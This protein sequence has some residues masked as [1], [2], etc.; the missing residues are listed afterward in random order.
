MPLVINSNIS[1]LN[2][3]RQ[4][5]NSG[6][7]LATAMERLSSGKRINTA[8]DD[9]AGLAISNRMTSQ[10]RGLDQAI[11]NAND[12][13]SLIQTAEGALDETT[14]I[15]QRMRELSIQSAN[16]IYSPA[17]R[18]NLDREVQQLKEELDRIAEST[19]FNGQPLLD[20]SL[21][22]MLLQVGSQANQTIKVSIGSM[23]SDSLGGIRGDVTGTGMS[24][25]FDP[26]GTP[27]GLGFAG[28]VTIN[29]QVLLQADL[30]GATNMDE[31]LELI[32]ENVQGVKASTMVEVKAAGVGTGVLGAGDSV[33]LSLIR[34]D[35]TSEGF[36]ITGTNTLLELAEKI[37]TQTE[38]AIK[39]TIDDD[40][41]LVLGSQNAQRLEVTLAGTGAAGATGTIATA[42]AS[43]IL[44]DTNPDNGD[45]ITVGYA[46]ADAALL[47]LDARTNDTLTGVVGDYTNPLL[48]GDMLIN[49][50]EIDGATTA[51]ELEAAINA[52][53]AETGVFAT[54]AAGI[55]TLQS[56]EEVS[57]AYTSTAAATTTGL[58]ATNSNEFIGN[59]IST[60]DISTAEGAQAAI[61]TIDV[62]LESISA[63]RSDMGAANNRLDFTINNLM[64]V[65]ENTSA[66]RSRIMDADFAAETAQL[67]RAQVLQQ[68]SQAM[69][70]QANALPQQVLQLLQG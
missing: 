41:K 64:V 30:N 12:G 4:L 21:G 61:A 45:D 13:I 36:V 26:A 25:T 39:A 57:I 47:G 20:G 60:I 38:G 29:G 2:A 46:A 33:S 48:A 50:V 54:N 70:A 1:S 18:A 22:D 49:G 58:Q 53:A 11:R 34:N 15:L 62:A 31:F 35:G 32:N 7:E 19:T 6:N 52:V 27:P 63:T 28:D 24:D 23:D 69:L 67:S 5:V 55:I 59:T 16:G 17:D 44:N 56:K 9:A 66:A 40:G 65:S 14:N 51:I 43:L 37:T 3:Q 42:N 10:V 8:A 68:A